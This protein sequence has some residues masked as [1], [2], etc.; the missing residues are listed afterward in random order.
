MRSLA[1]LACLAVASAIVSIPV[2]KMES[3]NA[4]NRRSGV[5]YDWPAKTKQLR[6]DGPVPVP[7]HNFQDA[8]YYGPITAGTPPQNFM[9]I[10][11]TGSSNLWVPSAKCTSFNCIFRAK[12]KS[13]QSSTYR[14]NGTKFD[15]EYGSGPVSGFLSQDSVGWGGLTVKGQLFAEITDASGLG[16]A[17]LAGKFDGI[18]G[19]AFQSISIY[20]IPTVFQMMLDQKLISDAIFA[21]YLSSTSGQDGVLTLGGTDPNHY[22]GSLFWVPLVSETYWEVKLDSL[23]LGGKNVSAAPYA[24]L[25]TGTSILA[26]PS[27]EVAAIAKSVGAVPFPLNPKEYTIDCNK[28]PSLPILSVGLGGRVFNL[29]GSDYV[30]NV[31]DTT[32]L[33]GMLGIDI[34][35]PRGPLWIMGDIFLR[36][37]YVAFDLG[38]NRVGI[39]PSK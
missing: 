35:A 8:Q 31:E 14:P 13:A 36:K 10:F 30:I 22:Q 3:L 1:L 23:R 39:A 16:A 19:M 11:D 9:V 25:D 28:V 17:F 37:Y 20:G 7:L 27:A 29:T 21:F 15:I 24:V 4:I 18:L 32:C 6:S 26:G 34:P 5:A 33:F 38:Q 12:Y 2:K